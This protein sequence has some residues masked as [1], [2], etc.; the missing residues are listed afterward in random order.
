MNDWI[1]TSENL[2]EE[3]KAVLISFKELDSDTRFANGIDI[4]YLIKDPISNK[5]YWMTKTIDFDLDEVVAWQ[6]LP[7]PY[8]G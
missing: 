2:P 1:L 5:L 3:K 7:T 8:R 6:P 4:A